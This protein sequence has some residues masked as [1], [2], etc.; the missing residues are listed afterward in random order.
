[1]GALLRNK[2]S[3]K[4]ITAVKRNGRMPLNSVQTPK[5][6]KK[7]KKM[8]LWKLGIYSLMQWGKWSWLKHIS[9]PSSANESAVTLSLS[10]VPQFIICTWQALQEPIQ[11]C[12]RHSH[13]KAWQPETSTPS[14]QT[15]GGKIL[16]IKKSNCQA[17]RPERFFILLEQETRSVMRKGRKGK[18]DDWTH[19]K[20][21]VS[22][23]GSGHP[24]EEWAAC[25]AKAVRVL[26][27]EFVQVRTPSS[28]IAVLA[29]KNLVVSAEITDMQVKQWVG[30]RGNNKVQ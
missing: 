23:H 21:C 30:L 2:P 6:F 24:T 5:S 18:K 22:N 12:L 4:I 13:S 27:T 25:P 28:V 11:E 16:G 17:H 7:F 1:M 14:F 15:E 20:C 10:S 26:G 9:I 29:E 19:Q 3:L 8:L